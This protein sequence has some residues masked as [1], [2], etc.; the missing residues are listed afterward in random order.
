MKTKRVPYEPVN[1]WCSRNSVAVV[2]H[3]CIIGP[4]MFGVLLAIDH[5]EH[6]DRGSV[7]R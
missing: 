4:T 5:Q 7:A 6:F 2:Y 1:L 3:L